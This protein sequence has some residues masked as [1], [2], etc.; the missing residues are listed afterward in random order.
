MEAVEQ[1]AVAASAA[2]TAR[3]TATEPRLAC[4][5]AV[6]LACLF[7][8]PPTARYC[9][10]AKVSGLPRRRAHWGTDTRRATGHQS[11]NLSL[12]TR[13]D[14][15]WPL[16]QV[17]QRGTK[18]GPEQGHIT[19]VVACQ[20]SHSTKTGADAARAA[21]RSRSEQPGVFARSTHDIVIV[22]ET[23]TF[24]EDY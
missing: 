8:A 21:P 6:V 20:L 15:P 18:E 23:S 9:E 17:L 19:L 22:P 1:V 5:P 24:S 11:V 13:K 2:C 16:R 10:G 14:T 4:P 12:H 7:R 3:V